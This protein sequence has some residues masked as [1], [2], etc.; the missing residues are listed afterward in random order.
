[1]AQK[2]TK[3]LTD[4]QVLENAICEQKTTTQQYVS[5]WKE[6]KMYGEFSQWYLSEFT[7]NEG[8]TYKNTEQYMMYQKA[9]LFGD[10]VTAKLILQAN[11]PAE[12]KKL[13]RQVSGFDEEIWKMHREA[14]VYDGNYFKFSQNPR[15]KQLMLSKAGMKFVE[16]SPYDRIWGIGY[17]TNEAPKHYQTWGLNLL[18]KALNK[19]QAK[20]LAEKKA[21]EMKKV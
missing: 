21:E 18:G 4:K 3:Q 6:D 5:F 16:A 13:G 2:S 11:T 20:L 14:I 8:I 7:D 15:L 17:T 19:V 9:C 1:M 12:I 10:A